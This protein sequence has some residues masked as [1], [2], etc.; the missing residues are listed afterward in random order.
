MDHGR[1]WAV[2][3]LYDKFLLYVNL[4][5]QNTYIYTHISLDYYYLI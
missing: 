4:Q 5:V 3:L 2:S 1:N